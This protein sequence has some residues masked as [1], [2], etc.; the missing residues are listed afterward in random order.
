MARDVKV[1]KYTSDD[2]AASINVDISRIPRNG[3]V[4][5]V[6]AKAILRKV[7]LLFA[8]SCLLLLYQPTNTCMLYSFTPTIIII[9]NI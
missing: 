6:G 9:M 7:S 8:F 1:F 5:I 4:D 3:A 2:M